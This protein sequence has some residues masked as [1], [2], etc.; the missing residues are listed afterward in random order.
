MSLMHGF[1]RADP[2]SYVKLSHALATVQKK[3]QPY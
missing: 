3:L 1:G 2:I